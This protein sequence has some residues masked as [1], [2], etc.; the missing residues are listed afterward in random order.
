M[1]K[2]LIGISCGISD[3]TVSKINARKKQEL[4]DT[5]VRAVEESGGIPV[6]IPNGLDEET[7]RELAKR[8]DAFVF[9]GGGDVDPSLYG[10]ET[11]ETVGGVS[12]KRDD[13]EYRLLR[14]VLKNTEKP[15]FGICRGVQMLNVAMGGTLLVDVEKAGKMRHSLTENPREDF[16]HEIIVKEGTRLEKILKEE[17]RVN[18]FHHQV[19]DR[20]AEGLTVTACSSLDQV[21][22]AVEAPGERY[23]LGVQW[24][25]EELIAHEAHKALFEELIAQAAALMQKEEI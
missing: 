13:T 18:S 15:V 16:S 2:P 24:H 11:D 5:Y 12:E 7:I 14:E 22:E 1:R 8:L 20:I 3:Y 23:I 6:I 9:S 10:K 4:N 19:L 21:V 17:R 25:P